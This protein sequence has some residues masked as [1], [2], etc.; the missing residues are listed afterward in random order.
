[1]N[2]SLYFMAGF[3][4]MA[5]VSH[6]LTPRFFLKMMP[7]FVPF[8]KPIVYISGVFEMTFAVMLLFAEWRSLAAWLIIGLLIAVFPAN[9]QMT[10]D[11]WKKKKPF[12][13][14]TIVR[15]PL[16]AV[17]IWWAWLFT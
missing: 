2:V 14:A 15:L 6:F 5:G 11:F 4:F 8:H 17:L 1:M 9:V 13:W 3:Y 16:Q 7:S 10:V 12:L